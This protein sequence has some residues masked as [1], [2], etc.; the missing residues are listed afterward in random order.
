MRTKL[1]LSLLL[2]A[3]QTG[4][5]VRMPADAPVAVRSRVG[6]FATVKQD[7]VL[8]DYVDSYVAQADDLPDRKYVAKLPRGS[9]VKVEGVVSRR[10]PPGVSYY[11]VCRSDAVSQKFDVQVDNYWEKGNGEPLYLDFSP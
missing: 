7:L 4:C 1:T 9:K 6:Q 5:W 8:C 2:L 3:T 11:Y 10:L